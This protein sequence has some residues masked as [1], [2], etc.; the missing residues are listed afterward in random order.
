M[1][2]YPTPPEGANVGHNHGLLPSKAKGV[3]KFM[4]VVV[5]YFTK[6]VEVE[7]LVSIT[8]QTI[9]KFLWKSL[10]C[11]FSIPQGLMLDNGK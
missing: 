10:V 8:S 4:M 11:R 9:M 6:W 5:N 2:W 1:D 7:A 3:A